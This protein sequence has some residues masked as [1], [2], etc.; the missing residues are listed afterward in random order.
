MVA[1]AQSRPQRRPSGCHEGRLPRGV[2]LGAVVLGAVVLGAVVLGA[3]RVGMGVREVRACPSAHRRLGR[4]ASQAAAASKA[5]Q[6]KDTDTR[7]NEN[8]QLI[9]A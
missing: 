6:W 2:V 9:F 7:S 1:H 8:L 5:G 4:A 3:V